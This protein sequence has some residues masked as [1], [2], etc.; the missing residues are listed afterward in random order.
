MEKVY[1]ESEI[2]EF[3]HREASCIGV[4]KKSDEICTKGRIEG[5]EK[6]V[7]S[8]EVTHRWVFSFEIKET[9]QRKVRENLC[10]LQQVDILAVRA[11]D[12]YFIATEHKDLH[13]VLKV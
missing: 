7:Y 13:L 5:Q 1:L 4:L 3:F 11:S 2:G 9:C 10:D 6:Y 8:V 12:V